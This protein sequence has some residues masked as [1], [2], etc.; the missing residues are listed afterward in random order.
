MWRMGARREAVRITQWYHG[1]DAVLR[2]SRG[3]NTH[4]FMVNTDVEREG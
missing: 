4:V 3:D 2:G 1:M